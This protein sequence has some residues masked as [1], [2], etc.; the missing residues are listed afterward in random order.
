MKR[1]LALSVVAAVAAAS[2][3]AVSAR[4][5][6]PPKGGEPAAGANTCP[7][8]LKK[9]DQ[10]YLAAMVG[11][12]TATYTATG[13]D[14]K[15]VTGAGTSKVSLG[16]GGSALVEDYTATGMMGAD[17][18]G[19]GVYRVS[20]DG[21][22]VTCWWFDSMNPEPMKFTGALTDT[23]VD[24][25]APMPGGQGTMKIVSKKVD[26]GF[27]WDATMDGKPMMSQ[28]MRKK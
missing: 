8:P 19:H 28:K 24:M 13:P 9:I 4:A 18:F 11:E 14:G 3:L 6:D 26:G 23:T 27:D 12:W 7:P 2:F 21:K 16:V 1:T 15:P 5:G 20:D 10:P 25:S 22:T 17:Y